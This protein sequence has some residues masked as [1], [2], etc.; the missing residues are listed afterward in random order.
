MPQPVHPGLITDVDREQARIALLISAYGGFLVR[1]G[2][3]PAHAAAGGPH[4][5]Q[6]C[7]VD[8]VAMCLPG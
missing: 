2:S 6:I 4:D 1:P 5:P 7:Q 8:V 3:R